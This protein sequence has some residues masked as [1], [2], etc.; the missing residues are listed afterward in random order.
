MVGRDV[1]PGPPPPVSGRGL[2]RPSCGSTGRSPQRGNVELARSLYRETLY[3]QQLLERVASDLEVLASNESDAA[4][5]RRLAARAMRIRR[6][7][8][9]G[10]PSDFD[11]SP[12]R[13]PPRF[14]GE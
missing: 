14:A 5:A 9:E 13:P 6:R 7:L 4:R 8:H 11:V 3:W 10:M 1:S 12:N 2:Q